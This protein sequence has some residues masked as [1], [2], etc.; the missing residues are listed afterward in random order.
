ML[1]YRSVFS[2][3]LKFSTCPVFW[4]AFRITYFGVLGS[5][6]ERF[7]FSKC[8]CSTTWNPNDPCFLL[9]RALFWRVEAQKIEDKEVPGIYYTIPE[10]PSKS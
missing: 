3:L 4:W 2:F 10:N 8:V 5:L 1:V 9:E 6:N 7:F